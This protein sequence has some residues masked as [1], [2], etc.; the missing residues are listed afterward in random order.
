M[1]LLLCALA[2][3]AAGVGTG[4][5]GL[6]AATVMV[7][8][9]I[10]L[11]PSFAG[12]TG[13]YHATAIALASDILGSAFTS[14][15][16]IRHKNIDLRRGGVM[17]ACIVCMCVAGSVAAWHAGNVVLGTFSL[18]L[19]VAIGVRFLLKPDTQRKEP[20]RKGARLD[21]KALA[22]SLFFGLTIG[23][24]T[25]F[26][27]SGGGMMMLVVFTAFLGMERK[28]AVGTSTLIMTFTALIAFVS[29]AL[30]DPTILLEKWEI[31]LLCMTVETAASIVSAQFANRVN[32]RTVGLVTGAVLS[33]LG[34]LLLAIQYREA[35]A[36][37]ALLMQVLRCFER[38]LVYLACWLAA[39]LLVKLF[40]PISK[41]L[42]RKSLHM[43]AYTSSL[44]MMH[45]SQDWLVSAL[46]CLSFAAVVYPL[47][48]YAE[49]WKGFASLLSQRKPG[50]IKASLLLLF[51]TH[52]ALIA[53][54]WGWLGKPYIAVTAILAWGTGDAAAALVGKRI[55]RHHIR[56]PLADPRKT[57][58]GSLAMLL[59][60][61]GAALAAML[62]ASPLPVSHCLLYAAVAA[63]V[64]AY[65]ELIS[66]GGLDTV[67][68]PTAA[69]LSLALLGLL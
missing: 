46:C 49:R 23:F 50:E 39:L 21:A 29:H 47:L 31:L 38:Y 4:L 6:S 28:A 55:G 32:N 25:G 66:H 18:F 43:V 51:C 59:T 42:W 30:V 2:A 44:F 48:H 13:A 65:T 33:V 63:P 57:W 35:L 10:V 64:S 26:I 45:A 22:V 17:L 24:G 27:G 69:A 56:L 14:A 34:A 62:A 41:E 61:F 20:A 40:L 67:T 16:Y 52:A 53:L 9:M 11:C 60:A 58:E 68:V 15:I 7:P 37:C 1:E 8:V 5:A 12:E 54:C 3:L 36:G 19:C